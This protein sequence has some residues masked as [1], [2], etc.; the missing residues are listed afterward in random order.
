MDLS[1]N[2]E[3]YL[4]AIF[5][6][7]RETPAVRVRDVA[8][9]LGVTMPSVNGALKNLEGRG[10]IRHQ[11]YEYIELTE[12]GASAAS[13]IAARHRTIVVF[14]RELIGVDAETAEKEACRMEHVLSVET[15]EKLTGY[16]ETH[17]NGGV[18]EKICKP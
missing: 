7:A 4:E 6:I 12:T 14:L 13:R 18:R 16:I 2:M 17:C 3:D 15:M 10:L 11:K 5:E 8:R 9:K 1:S